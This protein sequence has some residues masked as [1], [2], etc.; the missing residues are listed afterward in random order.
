MPAAANCPL[1][2]EINPDTYPCTPTC[3]C[4]GTP[5]EPAGCCAAACLGAVAG[6][7][8]TAMAE[9]LGAP[10]GGCLVGISWAVGLSRLLGDCRKLRLLPVAS[11]AAARAGGMVAPG[12]AIGCGGCSVDADTER[13]MGAGSGAEEAVGKPGGSCGSG[14]DPGVIAMGAIYSALADVVAVAV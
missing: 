8:C 4:L 2:P 9:G 5:C 7:C 1:M 14:A 3:T 6:L 11:C 13:D 12:T 10:V